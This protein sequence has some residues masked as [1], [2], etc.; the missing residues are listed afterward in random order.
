MIYYEPIKVFID[1]LGLAEAIINIV[2]LYYSL[3]D[4]IITNR[5]SLFILKFW[6]LLYYFLDIK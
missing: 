3:P 1:A 2:I 6:S 4:S 5:E